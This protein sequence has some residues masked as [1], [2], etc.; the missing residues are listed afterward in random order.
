MD[1]I[2]K[3]TEMTTTVR[4]KIRETPEQTEATVMALLKSGSSEVIYAQ[5]QRCMV[6]A[7]WVAL[8]SPQPLEG[9]SA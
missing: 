4:E 8:D 1:L 6:G 3:H 9:C 5:R 2:D 7:I